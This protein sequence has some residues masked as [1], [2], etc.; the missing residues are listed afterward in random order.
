M[1][2]SYLFFSLAPANSGKIIFILLNGVSE[3]E[4]SGGCRESEKPNQEFKLE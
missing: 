3:V 2:K 4:L 1:G